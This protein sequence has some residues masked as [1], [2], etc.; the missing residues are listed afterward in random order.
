M[1]RP[2]LIL[3]VHTLLRLYGTINIYINLITLC[4]WF[5]SH[6]FTQFICLYHSI[7]SDSLQFTDYFLYGKFNPFFPVCTLFP[8]IP[9]FLEHL[10]FR[11]SVDKLIIQDILC[12]STDYLQL[13][14]MCIWLPQI[15]IQYILVVNFSEMSAIL[16]ARAFA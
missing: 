16:T 15:I 6:I 8:L 9:S 4:P 2:Q 11:R 10:I 5:L 1:W 14:L 13:Y 7:S 12:S 3:F